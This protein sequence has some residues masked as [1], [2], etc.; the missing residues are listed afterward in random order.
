MADETA[1]LDGAEAPQLITLEVNY[2]GLFRMFM[3]QAE[4]DL[5]QWGRRGSV[6]EIEPLHRLLSSVATAA[7]CISNSAELQRLRDVLYQGLTA[8][9]A[10]HRQL[11]QEADDKEE[12]Q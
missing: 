4:T 12:G 10:R 6:A 1:K 7:G 8:I 2:G 9:N 11:D 5:R 3:E